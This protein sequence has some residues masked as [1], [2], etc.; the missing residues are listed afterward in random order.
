MSLKE[1]DGI[2]SLTSLGYAVKTKEGRRTPAMKSQWWGHHACRMERM[3]AF[4]TAVSQITGSSGPDRRLGRL[5]EGG[6]E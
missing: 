3:D 1:K 5:Q 4:N 6:W 2:W